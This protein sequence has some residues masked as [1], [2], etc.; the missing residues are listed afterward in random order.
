MKDRLTKHTDEE[1]VAL[2]NS[3]AHSLTF[4]ELLALAGQRLTDKVDRAENWMGNTSVS[5][6]VDTK[7]DCALVQTHLE[8]ALTRYNSAC[9]R[10]VGT[11]KRVDPDRKGE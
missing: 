11:W 8:D 3:Y 5:D 7:R 1:L 9:Y 2:E 10:L 4:N 6:K